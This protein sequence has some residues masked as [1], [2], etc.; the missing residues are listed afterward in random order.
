MAECR[1]VLS[2]HASKELY[3]TLE[4]RPFRDE[5]AEAFYR[6]PGIVFGNYTGKPI[7]P[8][9]PEVT[10]RPE[11]ALAAFED[12]KLTTTYG[13]YPFTQ[14]LNGGKARAAGVTFVGTLP[15]FRRRG[16][17]RKIMEFD[18]KRRYEERLEPVAILLASI[19]SIYQR[20][21]YACVSTCVR[22]DIDPRWVSFVPSMPKAT[23]TWREA[24]KDEQPFLE[25]MF[26]DFIEPRNGWLRRGKP[27]WDMQVFA[28]QTY[29]GVN[30]G[31]SLIAVYEEKGEPQGYIAWAAKW[32]HGSPSDAGGPG[33]RIYVRDYV[34]KSP[35][36][37]RAMWEYLKNFDLAARIV[38]DAAPTDDPAFHVLQD[39]RELHATQR[40]WMHG[41]IIDLE[42]VL[43]LRPYGAEGSVVFQVL[44]E[45]CPWNAD[46]WKLEAGPEGSAVSRTKESP[47]LS[48]DVSGLAQILYGQV[49]PTNAVRYGR[50]E[51]SRDADLK[52][53]DAM[54]RTEYA[55][56]C[57]NQF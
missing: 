14:R 18:F 52:L 47:S 40:D 20:Y 9:G 21:G 44:D 31:P 6:V 35:S 37:Y 30:P 8:N 32:T 7:D 45:M 16:H 49:S 27:M 48:L 4:I 56:F 51:A 36:T 2:A 26:T 13:A 10:L 15:E 24:T 43:P 46:T 54:W 50:A 33:Q 12:G 38:F 55:P 57:P 34:Y 25:E 3:V 23:G 39:P 22:F 42:R 29:D 53:W 11:W 5:E 1:L 17:L 19:A 41:R 28:G